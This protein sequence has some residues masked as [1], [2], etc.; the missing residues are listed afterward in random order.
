MAALVSIGLISAS[1]ATNYWGLAR[2]EAEE[3]H[4]SAFDVRG[5]IE[6]L[7]PDGYEYRTAVDL[8]RLTCRLTD[9]L[10]S[11]SAPQKVDDWFYQVEIAHRRLSEHVAA[12]CLRDDWRLLR[13]MEDLCNDLRDLKRALDRCRCSVP[14]GP[15]IQLPLQTP[16]YR[17]P[18]AFGPSYPRGQFE[19]P[20]GATPWSQPLPPGSAVPAPLPY[21][22]EP[23]IPI[24][25]PNA[26]DQLKKDLMRLI[27]SK[28]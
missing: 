11:N 9:A 5:R 18:P 23:G 27:F 24:H 6:R 2:G 4:D 28:I 14:T 25:A 19:Y 26:K 20:H 13:D 16:A 17:F 12:S 15:A 1:E 21:P 22:T 7:D 8:E 3:V 10:A